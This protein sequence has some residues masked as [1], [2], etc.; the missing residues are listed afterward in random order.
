MIQSFKDDTTEDIYNGVSSKKVLKRLPVILWRV[1][2]L[3][4]YSLDNAVSLHDLSAPPSNR[5]EAL[6][7]DRK[8]LYSIRINEQYRICFRWTAQGPE[9][10]E[11]VDY[12]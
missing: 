3:K 12:H 10:L 7:G 11:I 2:Y 4:F 8:G 9:L 1:A 5:L 6:K